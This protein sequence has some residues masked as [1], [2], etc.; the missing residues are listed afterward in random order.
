MVMENSEKIGHIIGSIVDIV[1]HRIGV[2]GQNSKKAA[3]SKLE[4]ISEY[5]KGKADAYGEV[6]DLLSTL[7]QI[8]E[9]S[10]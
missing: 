2:Y 9:Q 6:L 8:Y 3:L 10:Q 1:E 4:R 5:Y 7:K